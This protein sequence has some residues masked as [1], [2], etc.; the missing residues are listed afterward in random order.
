MKEI[1]FNRFQT[2]IVKNADNT[3]LKMCYFFLE[4]FLTLKKSLFHC[5]NDLRLIIVFFIINLIKS[6]EK[7]SLPN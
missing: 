4:L 1:E 5:F 6:N 2:T 7:N 3:I